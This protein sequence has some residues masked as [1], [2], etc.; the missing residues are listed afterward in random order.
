VLSL[1]GTCLI[2]LEQ[3]HQRRNATMITKDLKIHVVNFS[4]Q[5]PTREEC[6]LIVLAILKEYDRHI[7]SSDFLYDTYGKPYLDESLSFA[8]S[9]SHSAKQLVVGIAEG[10][11]SIGVDTEVVA[12]AKELEQVK[13]MA[14]STSE[15]GFIKSNAFLGHWCLKEAAVKCEGRG[16]R[17]ETPSHTTLRIVG[18]SYELWEKRTKIG[19]G[20]YVKFQDRNSIIVVCSQNS[21]LLTERSTYEMEDD[22]LNRVRLGSWGTDWNK[23]RLTT[24]VNNTKLHERKGVSDS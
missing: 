20:Y 10:I 9:Y 13:D 18:K 12:R 11:Q 22:D 16:F 7:A 23:R 19:Q 17:Y 8:F 24:Q 3:K 6:R 15:L 4:A 14:F 21:L 1:T 2:Q 5:K